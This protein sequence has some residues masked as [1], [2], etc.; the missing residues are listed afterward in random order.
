MTNKDR[1]ITKHTVLTELRKGDLLITDEDAILDE[2]D[3]LWD[4][5]SPQEQAELREV[6]KWQN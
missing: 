2:L 1:Y 4:N 3:I 5:C 6:L